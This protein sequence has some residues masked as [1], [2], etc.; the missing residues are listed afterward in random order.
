MKIF[1]EKKIF[2]VPLISHNFGQKIF[3]TSEYPPPS[4]GI[5]EIQKSILRNEKHHKNK[6]EFHVFSWYTKKH[7]IQHYSHSVVHL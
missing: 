1:R 5:V 2:Q 6:I 7:T 3:I 4:G